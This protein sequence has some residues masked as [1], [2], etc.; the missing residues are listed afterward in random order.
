MKL[1]FMDFETY[2]SKEYTLKKLTPIEYILDSRFECHGMAVKQGLARKSEWVP[3]PEI[4][5]YLHLLDRFEVAMVSH[6]ALFD[7]AILAWRYNYVP[8]R[9]IDTLGMARAM[10]G[11]KL[12]SLSLNNVS[13]YLGFGMKGDTVNKTLGVHQS[14]LVWNVSLHNELAA[15]SCDD[16][17]KC[18]QIFKALIKDFP[19]KELDVMNLVIRACVLPQFKLN[20]TVL[21]Q[22]MIRV[23]GDKRRALELAQVHDAGNLRSNEKFAELLR[24]LGVDPPMK[25]SLTTG[26]ETYAFAKTDSSFIDLAEHDDPKVQALVAARLGHKST[27]EETRTQKLLAISNLTWPVGERWMP[28]PLR[29]SGAH[30]HRLS[31]DMKLNMQN[32]PRRSALRRALVAPIGSQVISI[33]L[34]Q[35]EARIVAWICEQLDL[36]EAFAMGTDVYSEFAETVFTL[37]VSRTVNPNMRFIGKTAIL[38]LGYGMSHNKFMVSVKSGSKNQLGKVIEMLPA[39]A[40]KV[41][42]VYRSKYSR[43]AG[44]WNRLQGVGMNTLANGGTWVFGPCIFGLNEIRLPNDLKLFYDDLQSMSQGGTINNWRFR[45]G[46]RFKFV[47]GAKLLENITQA[48]A[49][50]IIKELALRAQDEGMRFAHQVHD[51]LLFVVKNKYVE[52]TRERLLELAAIRPDWAPELPLASETKFGPSYGEMVT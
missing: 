51:E 36:L 47:Y 9:L 34:A 50:I 25:V 19:A 27:L 37:E 41:V 24:E 39:V 35:I 40:Q 46:G 48:L 18:A 42:Q 44:S 33:D 13:Q 16:N 12:K 31:G 6:N 17:D 30:T 5:A 21:E 20:R 28:V 23:L 43:I 45:Y 8:V 22:H 1:V 15:Y 2:Y 29:F 14:Q 4:P 49:Q 32:L 3:G 10:L 11:H 52:R 7:A 38:G 26:K